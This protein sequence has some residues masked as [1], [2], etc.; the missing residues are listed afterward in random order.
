[1]HPLFILDWAIIAVSFFN[2][3]ILLWLGLTVL[4][5]ADRRRW[6][7]WAAGGGFLFSGLF[8]IG[9]TA[10]VGRVIGTFEPEME[11]W[12]RMSWLL[13]AS[14]PYMW[15]LV[16]LAYTGLLESG[17]HRSWLLTVTL[18]GIMAVALLGLTDPLPT[19]Q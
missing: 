5:N 9:H 8:F 4:L 11:L 18:L 19:Y 10:I 15:Y 13:V 6:G 2:T 1:M 12:W 17:R 7:T 3:V 14:A 16:M